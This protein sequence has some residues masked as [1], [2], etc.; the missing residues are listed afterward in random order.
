LGLLLEAAERAPR[1][2]AGEGPLWLNRNAEAGWTGT[3]ENGW[4]CAEPTMGG[5]GALMRLR[6]VVWGVKL[7]R[8]PKPDR[9]SLI[10]RLLLGIIV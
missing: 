3:D 4:N 5:G 2:S 1:E 10:P 8:L 9:S 7:C 6:D